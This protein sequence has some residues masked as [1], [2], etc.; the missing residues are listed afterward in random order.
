VGPSNRAHIVCWSTLLWGD[1]PLPPRPSAG[2]PC[3]AACLEA[4]AANPLSNPAF[5]SFCRAS[6]T[7]ITECLNVQ[8]SS[9]HHPRRIKLVQSPFAP[10]ARSWY[11]TP[12]FRVNVMMFISG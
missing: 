12:L 11:L 8:F 5:T 7:V 1:G 9:G 6:G 10:T 4:N 2:L 3:Q